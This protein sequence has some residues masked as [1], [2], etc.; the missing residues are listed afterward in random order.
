MRS[1]FL[2]CFC[3]LGAALIPR[4]HLSGV[5]AESFSVHQI[6]S[7]WW[8]PSSHL[9]LSHQSLQSSSA[10]WETLLSA[11]F[12]GTL[13]WAHAVQELIVG[14]KEKMHMD[15]RLTLC[16][17]YSLRSKLPRS[18]PASSNEFKI[19]HSTSGDQRGHYR[20]QT[21]PRD[22]SLRTWDWKVSVW[23]LVLWFS[24]AKLPNHHPQSSSHRKH[25]T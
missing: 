15:F 21:G 5:S 8:L 23:H 17:S 9:F 14:S 4:V 7:T 24:S 25:T 1:V 11:S 10:A 20:E 13:P 3:S 2:N 16:S 6:F 18:C 12:L 19:V 22:H